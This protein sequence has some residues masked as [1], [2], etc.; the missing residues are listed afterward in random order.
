MGTCGQSTT[1][2]RTYGIDR[3]GNSHSVPH[4]ALR[5][6]P[7]VLL[8]RPVCPPGPSTRLLQTCRRGAALHHGSCRTSHRTFGISPTNSGRGGQTAPGQCLW[9]TRT[10][11]SRPH[12]ALIRFV[13]LSTAAPLGAERARLNHA[14][15]THNRPVVGPAAR[16][17]HRPSRTCITHCLEQP[18]KPA[19]CHGMREL[20]SPVPSPQARVSTT[21]RPRIPSGLR[22]VPGPRAQPHATAR[23]VPSIA[24]P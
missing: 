10:P 2:P 9:L 3:G 16:E 14:S 7:E 12:K 4:A 15:W 13:R 8:C 1:G 6:D 18:V 19:Q 21:H 22:G 20:L 5:P 23:P 24:R 17:R 11:S